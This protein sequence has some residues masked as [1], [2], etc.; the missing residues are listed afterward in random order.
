MFDNCSDILF[1][2]ICTNRMI[3]AGINHSHRALIVK[4]IDQIENIQV[5]VQFM[6]YVHSQIVH[7]FFLVC[8]HQV[9]VFLN[10]LN[11]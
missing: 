5:T 1:T 2:Y 9:K 8:I 3:E 6:K 7:C 11:S 10:L 4:N